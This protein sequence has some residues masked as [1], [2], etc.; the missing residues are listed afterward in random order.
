MDE[1]VNNGAQ[2]LYLK[3]LNITTDRFSKDMVD[4]LTGLV[5]GAPVSH[6]PSEDHPSTHECCNVVFVLC[7]PRLLADRALQ[8]NLC[9]SRHHL[10]ILLHCCCG[11]HLGRCCQFLGQFISGSICSG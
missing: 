4:N 3:E 6:P 5:V 7:N 9:S 8:Q 11:L 2:A 1:T 10:Y